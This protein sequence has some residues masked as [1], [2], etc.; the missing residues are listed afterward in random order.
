MTGKGKWV[1]QQECPLE[2]VISGQEIKRDPG[3][4]ESGDQIQFFKSEG[5]GAVVHSSGLAV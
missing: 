4:T 3:R 5:F 2:E 1:A